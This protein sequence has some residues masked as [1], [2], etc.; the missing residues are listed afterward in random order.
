[1]LEINKVG[2]VAFILGCCIK[3]RQ[4]ATNDSNV[5]KNGPFPKEIANIIN[6]IYNLSPKHRFVLKPL[7]WNFAYFL[8]K[9]SK[10]NLGCF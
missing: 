8:Y 7:L 4:S 10:L 5:F 2:A 3:W 6:E 9:W 1:M